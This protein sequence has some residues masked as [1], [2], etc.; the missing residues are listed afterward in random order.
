M[1]GETW[2]AL[3]TSPA[4]TVTYP[5]SVATKPLE[6]GCYRQIF[7]TTEGRVFRQWSTCDGSA[8]GAVG[9]VRCSCRK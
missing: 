3:G 5:Y 9:P 8:V 7:A 1:T 2:P 6:T 4:K